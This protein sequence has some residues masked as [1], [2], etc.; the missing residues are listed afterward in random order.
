MKFTT[1]Q[2]IQDL[3]DDHLQDPEAPPLSDVIVL[4]ETDD[5]VYP[6]HTNGQFGIDD[7]E[8][9]PSLTIGFIPITADI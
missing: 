6:V 4:V 7:D 9:M 2:D 5:D 1:L 3:I 8:S